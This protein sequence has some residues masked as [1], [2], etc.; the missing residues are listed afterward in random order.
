M[1]VGKKET[2]NNS[3]TSLHES[4]MTHDDRGENDVEVFTFYHLLVKGKIYRYVLPYNTCSV[5]LSHSCHLVIY[6]RI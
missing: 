5:F 3:I 1:G 2:F 4:Y 6:E